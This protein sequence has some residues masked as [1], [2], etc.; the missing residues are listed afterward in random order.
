M[1]THRIPRPVPRLALVLLAVAVVGGA[2]LALLLTL[3]PVAR[4]ATVGGPAAEVTARYDGDCR[5][6]MR[7][8]CPS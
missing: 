6:T 2:A 7:I 4:P 5:P 1:T 3:A 8:P